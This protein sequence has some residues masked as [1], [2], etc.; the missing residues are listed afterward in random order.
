V[1]RYW[2]HPTAV[3]ERPVRIGPGTK[4]WHFSHVLPGARIGARCV[5][6]QNVYVAGSASIGDGCRIQ[7]NVS[8]YDGV[9][10]EPD[11]FVGP[12][13]VFTNVRNP[14]AFVSRK[15][16]LEA[17]IVERGASV[18]AN[19]TIVSGTRIGA[20]AFIAAGAVVTRDVPAHAVVSGVPARRMAWTCRCGDTRGSAQAIRRCPCFAPA[21]RGRG[22]RKKLP[23]AST[24]RSISSSRSS[25]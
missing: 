12:S 19:A 1:T 7:N 8:I 2:A 10:L 5:L 24:T 21:R 3:V 23:T 13:A 11:V 17:T 9:R 6:G 14:R 25:G 18:G 4:I 15:D 20:Y 22:Q 16:E